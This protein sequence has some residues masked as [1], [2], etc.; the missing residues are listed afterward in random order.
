LPSLMLYRFGAG[1]KLIAASSFCAHNLAGERRVTA[2]HTTPNATTSGNTRGTVSKSIGGGRRGAHPRCRTCSIRVRSRKTIGLLCGATSRR[3][4]NGYAD[5][6]VRGSSPV[7]ARL[8][9][10]V[11]D[12]IAQG[13]RLF[14]ERRAVFDS[15]G[16]W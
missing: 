16:T 7:Q 1:R 3:A 11:R 9:Q 12:H 6:M 8:K 10:M 2:R 13:A 4:G 15:R 14:V 5:S